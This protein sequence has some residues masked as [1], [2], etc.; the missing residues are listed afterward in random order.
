MYCNWLF[1]LVRYVY[2]YNDRHLI[3]VCYDRYLILFDSV[4][5]YF[6]YCLSIYCTDIVFTIYWLLLLYCTIPLPSFY[7]LTGSFLTPLSL[8]I[9]VWLFHLLIRYLGRITL[10]TRMP[11]VLL[12]K[13]LSFIIS[14]CF[15][16]FLILYIRGLSFY[17]IWL[18][19][20][21]Y[22]LCKNLY[23]IW[24]WIYCIHNRLI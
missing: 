5:I 15:L 2:M 13:S 12:D 23:G 7:T 14:S 11:R 10:L 9:Q 4:T 24:Q 19:I 16:F 6:H 20:E 3:Y 1:S 21:Y 8:H 18:F 17:S 22:I